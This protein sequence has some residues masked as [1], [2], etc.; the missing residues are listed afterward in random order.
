MKLM[1][2]KTHVPLPSG[3]NII[4]HLTQIS[5]V[6]AGG[7]I[8]L[9]FSPPFG[10]K[11]SV[12]KKTDFLKPLRS[13]GPPCLDDGAMICFLPTGLHFT[14]STEPKVGFFAVGSGNTWKSCVISNLILSQM[15]FFPNLGV[16]IPKQQ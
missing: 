5:P 1:L 12:A 14:L 3:Q 11:F 16:D 9:N 8:S 6:W 13:A 10:G 4:F 2:K 7:P 15:V